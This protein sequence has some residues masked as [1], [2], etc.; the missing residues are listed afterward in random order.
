MGT[1]TVIT[2]DAVT[3]LEADVT[4]LTTKLNG[5]IIQY[6]KVQADMTLNKLAIDELK[7]EFNLA[8]ADLTNHTGKI[9]TLISDVKTGTNNHTSKIDSLITDV[10]KI[11]TLVT[12][13]TS[14][15]NKITS[16]YTAT[17]TTGGGDADDSILE[18]LSNLD[19]DFKELS[20]HYQN[21][22]TKPYDDSSYGHSSTGRSGNRG[23]GGGVGTPSTDRYIDI[24]E[25]STTSEGAATSSGTA[26]G[27]SSGTASDGSHTLILPTRD[28]SV[29]TDEATVTPSYSTGTVKVLTLGKKGEIRGK[30]LARQTLNRLRK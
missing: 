14:L 8:E 3:Q 29:S 13:V 4:E 18:R 24:D 11:G 21:H 17:Q 20:D 30:K 5:V 10:G 7:T 12:D 1:T 28:D 19:Q 16:G 2:S 23:G 6:N 25:A 26:S 9:D 27:A 22:V 15:K